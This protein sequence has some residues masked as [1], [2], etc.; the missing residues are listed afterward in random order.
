[1]NIVIMGTGGVG[2]YYGTKLLKGGN[3]VLFI[4]RGKHLEAM[5]TNGLHIIHPHFSFHKPVEACELKELRQH[6]YLPTINAILL[7][8]KADATREVAQTLKGLFGNELPYVVSLQNGVENEKVLLEYLP[9]EKVIGGLS[10]KLGAFIKEY[11]VIEGTGKP[12]TIVGALYPNKE[13]EAFLLQLKKTFEDA[14]LY[15]MISQNIQKDLWI[16]LV[17]NNGV[18]AL[19]ALLRE[20]TGVVMHNDKLSHLVYKLMEETASAAKSEDVKISKKEVDAMHKLITDFDSIKPSMQVDVESGRKI[21]L[22]EICGVVI[23]GCEALGEDAPYTRTVS[24][25]LDFTYHK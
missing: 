11:G 12:E 3:K 17:I 1:M 7:T 14:G 2:A 13:N 19:C 4:A 20:K 24:T 18:N 9:E 10:R 16:K 15:F 21:E 6:A 23:R 8:T 25:L 22:D 5:K